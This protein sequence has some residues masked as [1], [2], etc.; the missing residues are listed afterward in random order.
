MKRPETAGFVRVLTKPRV[1]VISEKEK[2]LDFS[3]EGKWV[4]IAL[5]G[6]R[7]AGD[8]AGTCASISLDFLSLSL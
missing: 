7:P 5:N 2:A 1:W 3:A 8:P 4:V 6:T